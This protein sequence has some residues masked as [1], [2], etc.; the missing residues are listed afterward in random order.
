MFVLTSV[1]ISVSWHN[2]AVVSF[3]AGRSIVY[4]NLYDSGLE[5]WFHR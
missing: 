2:D 1:M 3:L 5:R 4:S